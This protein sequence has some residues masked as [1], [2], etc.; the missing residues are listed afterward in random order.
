[1]IVQT[2]VKNGTIDAAQTG[3]WDI[4]LNRCQTGHLVSFQIQGI[5]IEEST[6]TLYGKLHPSQEWCQIDLGAVQT[7]NDTILRIPLCEQYRL[8]VENLQLAPMTISAWIAN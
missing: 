1:M 7:D 6:F 8:Q 3:T 4:L 5:V 2:I